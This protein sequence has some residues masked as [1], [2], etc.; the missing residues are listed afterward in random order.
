VL[1]LTRIPTLY[2]YLA[3][4]GIWGS[5]WL[6]ITWQLG[7]VAPEASVGYRFLL[8]SALLF[9]LCL[10]FRLPL[11]FSPRQHL[12]LALQGALMY[13]IS[14]LFVYHAEARLV[15]G[16]VAMGYSLSPLL[17]LV[18]V[19]AVYG[20][21]MS[22]RIA[23]G[24]L[25]GVAGIALVFSPGLAAFA[26][27]PDMARGAGL[28]AAA[29]I[30]STLGNVVATRNRERGLPVWQALA[31]GMLYGGACSLVVALSV[32]EALALA[33]TPGYLASLLYLSVLGSVLAFACYLTLLERM[34]AARAAYIGVM[35]PVVALVLSAAFEGLRWETATWV[36]VGLSIAGNAVILR[37]R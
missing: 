35:V 7:P 3:C 2:L 33:L 25:L 34:G 27:Q 13:S 6:A 31:W 19:R 14:Y 15:S 30:A 36:G 23:L 29:V 32:G 1:R 24:G 10:V 21:P 26:A 22:A 8:A 5:T 16:L 12:A 11:R 37:A 4:I 28:T 9:G 17:N 18:A 20:T